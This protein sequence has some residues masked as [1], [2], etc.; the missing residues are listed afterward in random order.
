MTVIIRT[1][2]GAVASTVPWITMLVALLTAETTAVT[3][4]PLKRT[5]EAP[6][7][8]VPET[9]AVNAAPCATE[10]GEIDFTEMGLACWTLN[11]LKGLD[12]PAGVVKV[13]V[14][15]PVAAPVATVTLT[16]TLVL[17]GT[18]ATTPV[19]PVPLNVTAVAPARFRPVIVTGIVVPGIASAGLIAVTVGALAAETENPLKAAEISSGVVTTRLCAPTGALAEIEIVTGR[20][21]AVAVPEIVAKTPGPLK[22]TEVTPLRF[23]PVMV[24]GIT[25]PCAP[26]ETLNDEMAGVLGLIVKPLNR[27]D[28]PFGVV[29]VAPCS[30]VEAV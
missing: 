8:L 22:A 28:V 14:R 16:C 4:F 18:P 3:P 26:D 7:R 20:L 19:T 25:L 30:P 11:P 23:D 2:V 10:E 9:V 6:V 1:P 13:I 21:V 24:A 12:V 5:A 29:T 27:L 17:V 15:T